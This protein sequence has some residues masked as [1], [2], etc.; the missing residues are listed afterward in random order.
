VD[1]AHN[2]N[3]TARPVAIPLIDARALVD[4]V[5]IVFAAGVVPA[6]M[7][8]LVS[9]F[10]ISIPW[11]DDWSWMTATIAVAHGSATEY[12]PFAGQSFPVLADLWGQHNE[13]R[14]FVPGVLALAISL[15]GG[16]SPKREELASVAIVTLDLAL[17]W[18]MMRATLP[19]N[20]I[21]PAFLGASLVLFSLVQYENWTWGFQIAWFTGTALALA[22]VYLLTREDLTRT[23][24]GFALAASVAAALSSAFG[25]VS[26]VVGFA[27]LLARRDTPPWSRAM[28]AGCGILAFALY[29]HDFHSR[30]TTIAGYL[31]GLDQLAPFLQHVLLYLGAPLGSWSATAFAGV[32]GFAG[33]L[34]YVTALARFV[35]LHI[36]HDRYARAYLPW[37]G[38]GGFAVLGALIT[39]FGRIAWANSAFQ[40]RYTTVSVL[41]WVAVIAL[42]AILPSDP[43]SR[44]WP[45]RGRARRAVAA[46][47]GAIFALLLWRTD[48]YGYD[49]MVAVQSRTENDVRALHHLDTASDSEL[50]DIF[51][52]DVNVARVF[53]KLL[54]LEG[55]GPLADDPALAFRGRGDE[56]A[57]G[58]V[59]SFAAVQGKSQLEIGGPVARGATVVARGWAIDS[60]ALKPGASVVALVDDKPVPQTSSYGAS[61]PRVAAGM[62]LRDLDHTGFAVRVDT[63][64]LAL[65]THTVTFFLK[66]PGNPRLHPLY[67]AKRTFELVAPQRVRPHKGSR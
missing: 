20:S 53:V 34:V 43:W 47:L 66:T 63:G 33:V 17:V 13:H 38:V 46:A 27:L 9:Q 48:A 4:A 3:A 58:S 50:V 62:R 49:N 44:A 19:A 56:P 8:W 39:T 57:L 65:G 36:V 54:T 7:F 45:V 21:A 6:M 22:S 31:P 41:F 23:K 11:A 59:T 16:W 52:P 10:G 24:F 12:S 26:P 2:A 35:R 60:V 15:L 29:A 55:V 67:Q 14:I 30:G 1:E 64:A 37:L 40:S 18:R 28:W 61:T 5:L 51:S 42:A 25:L 32:L